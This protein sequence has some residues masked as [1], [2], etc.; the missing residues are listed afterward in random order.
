MISST[1]LA[2][3]KYTII[4]DNGVLSALRHGEP[5]RKDDLVGDNLVGAMLDTILEQE[6]LL[7][8]IK[9]ELEKLACLGNGY[10]YGNSIGNGIA[11]RALNKLKA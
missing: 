7:V 8:D 1:P 9:E 2:N 10:H 4:S 6:L 11:Q 3:G 5:W